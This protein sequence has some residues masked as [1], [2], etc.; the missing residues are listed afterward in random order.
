MKGFIV[1][2]IKKEHSFEIDRI[3]IRIE[4]TD[5]EL[6]EQILK[7]NALILYAESEYNDLKKRIDAALSRVNRMSIGNFSHHLGNLKAILSGVK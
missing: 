1:S 7:K 2:K 5:P 3:G 6:I 4:I